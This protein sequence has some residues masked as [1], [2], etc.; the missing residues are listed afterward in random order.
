M[1]EKIK[2]KLKQNVSVYSGY[3]ALKRIQN[4]LLLS[5][6]SSG[7]YVFID[8]SK[9]SYTLIYILAG[10]KEYLYPF[11]LSRFSAF[12]LADADVCL[13]C[14]GKSSEILKKIAQENG[15]SCLFTQER[16]VGIVQNIAIRLHPM[17]RFIYKMDEDIF[18]TKGMFE[19]MQEAYN[20]VEKN[21]PYTPGFISPL[22]NVNG[23]SYHHI[24]EK[25]S[26]YE[27]YEGLFGTI[28]SGAN[29]KLAI[30]NNPDAAMFMWGLPS[31]YSEEKAS[32]LPTL[33]TL[34]AKC[35]ESFFE[36]SL[37]PSRIS[38]GMILFHRELW[39]SMLGFPVKKRNKP[40]LGVDESYICS[41]CFLNSRHMVLAHNVVAGHF[42]FTLQNEAMKEA[43][44]KHRDYFAFSDWLIHKDK[45]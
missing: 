37:I 26:K 9:G 3:T 8:R 45:K 43:L 5:H 17:A 14:A 27:E 34:N 19:R 16:N 21:S 6:R 31:T 12:I 23:V 41:Y 25:F 22:L 1:I 28:K 24:L 20:M 10:F 13:L 15:W 18:V 39:E 42:S 35:Q 30:E 38:I 4:R 2:R 32:S 29:S 11:T 33:D 36:Y 40:C 44:L 7:K